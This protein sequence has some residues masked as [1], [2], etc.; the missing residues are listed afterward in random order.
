MPPVPCSLIFLE[1]YF[2]ILLFIFFTLLINLAFLF[3]FGFLSNNPS[4]SDNKI[5]QS[6]P[7]ICAT[8]DANLSL[9][10]YFI[11]EVAILSFSLTN[12]INPRSKRLS[13]V[14]FAFIALLLIS[15]SSS[16]KSIWERFRVFSRIYQ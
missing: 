6:E 14:R 13:N 1:I 11:S 9:S 15:V 7:D 5:K 10:P 4:T 12:G 16:V 2:S 3:N 8:L